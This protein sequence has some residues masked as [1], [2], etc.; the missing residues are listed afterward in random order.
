MADFN[1]FMEGERGS[2]PDQVDWFPVKQQL[3][4]TFRPKKEADR[5]VD[6][7][8]GHSNGIALF[9]NKFP[10]TPGHLVLQD[11]A[12]VTGHVQDVTKDIERIKDGCFTPQSI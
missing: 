9:R 8:G 6:V 2:R 7:T 10:H 12:K 3:L 5:L 1:N 4:H 11:L